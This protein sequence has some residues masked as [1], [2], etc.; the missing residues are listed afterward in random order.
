MNKKVHLYLVGD[1][2]SKDNNHWLAMTNNKETAEALMEE[3]EGATLIKRFEFDDWE[4]A[5]EN[6]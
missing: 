1:D 6:E 2:N 4:E 3:I 5:E